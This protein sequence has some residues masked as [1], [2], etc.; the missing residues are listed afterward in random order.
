MACRNAATAPPTFSRALSR[1]PRANA[2][3]GAAS[4][5]PE[6]LAGPNAAT[7]PSIS[8]RARSLSPRL[9]DSS[10]DSPARP[11]FAWALAL[12]LASPA[13]ARA[14]TLTAAAAFSQSPIVR[15][16]FPVGLA[17]T[18]ILPPGVARQTVT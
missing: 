13:S 8:P 4:A 15:V 1:L 10:G 3:S 17:C 16:P 2:A 12:A 14:A 6:S 9:N 5:C 11:F 18:Y 7:A